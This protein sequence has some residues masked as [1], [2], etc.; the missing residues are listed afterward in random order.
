MLYIVTYI[1]LC[2]FVR[3]GLAYYKAALLW[4]ILLRGPKSVANLRWILPIKPSYVPRT[5]VQ[6]TEL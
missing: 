2:V 3:Y 6:N 5:N 1:S 4:K